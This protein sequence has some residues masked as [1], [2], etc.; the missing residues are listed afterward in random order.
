M[1]RVFESSHF[2]KTLGAR[3]TSRKQAS[4]NDLQNLQR[5]V[6]ETPVT[7]IV[8]HLQSLD[9]MQS[10]FGLTGGITFDNHMNALSDDAEEV[11]QRLE[12]QHLQPSTPHHPV[13]SKPRPR[14]DQICVYT[15]VE[16]LRKPA[17]VVEYKPPHKL[18]LAVLRQVLHPGR[19][20][21]EV[22]HF[23]N[24]VWMPGPEGTVT[25]FE[26]HAGHDWWP[27]S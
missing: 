3:V 10:E 19:A 13:L 2:I 12:A 16:G 15:T 20:K 1:P 24:W 17:L 8:E 18:T 11:A 23:I 5:E 25:H 22:D 4:E 6:V 7:L 26:Y 21:M 9:D 27:P 14:P